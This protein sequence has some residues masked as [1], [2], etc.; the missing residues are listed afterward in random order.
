M[1]TCLSS[2]SSCSYSNKRIII[3]LY[4]YIY[5]YIYIYC[6][7]NI[8]PLLI[9]RAVIFFYVVSYCI[10][11]MVTTIRYIDGYRTFIFLTT[12]IY[13]LV[14]CYVTLAFFNTLVDWCRMARYSSDDVAEAVPHIA[15][16]C[17]WLL[18]NLCLSGT[19]CTTVVFW[20]MYI[21]YV[22][23][24]DLFFP[25]M[26]R[27]I[28]LH[29]LP[30]IVML[31]TLIITRVEVRLAHVIYPEIL[32]LTYVAFTLVYWRAG[33]T[34]IGGIRF[35]YPILDYERRPV[36]AALV[37]VAM[38]VAVLAAQLLFK[39]IYVL[40]EYVM[41]K[42]GNRDNEVYDIERQPLTGSSVEMTEVKDTKYSE[43]KK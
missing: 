32:G 40:R 33:G 13:I 17:Q 22:D 18:F 23:I 16:K 21:Q 36:V 35:I 25:D 34:N 26:M 29:V 19:L 38:M 4:I 6:G 31:I 28:N 3:P 43:P 24:R 8:T 42:V 41:W 37:I 12:W 7:R 30:L 20:I 2:S 15:E 14:N 27:N 10:Y 9:Y 1:S 11:D 5:I 39:G